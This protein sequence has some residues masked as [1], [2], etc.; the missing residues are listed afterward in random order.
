ME[1]KYTNLPLGMWECD[2]FDGETIDDIRGHQ[3]LVYTD[4]LNEAEN[5]AHEILGNEKLLDLMAGAEGLAAEEVIHRL[6][7]AVEKYRAGAAPNDDLT[8]LCLRLL[9]K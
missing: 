2:K 3:L 8:L 7:K 5:P 1:L 6:Q 4:G 9:E